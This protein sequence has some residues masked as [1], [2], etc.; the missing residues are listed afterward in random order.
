MGPP[1]II[2][3][4]WPQPSRTVHRSPG[5]A[6]SPQRQPQHDKTVRNGGYLL[7]RW[8]AWWLRCDDHGPSAALAPAGARRWT[9]TFPR[10]H[11]TRWCL[12]RFPGKAPFWRSRGSGAYVPFALR[13]VPPGV[14]VDTVPPG[15]PPREEQTGRDDPPPIPPVARHRPRRAPRRQWPA[16]QARQ[17]PM[18]ATGTPALGAGGPAPAQPGGWLEDRP[19]AHRAHPACGPSARTPGPFIEFLTGQ[20]ARLEMLTQRRY[21][22]ITVGIG[23]PHLREPVPV[24][25][26]VHRYLPVFCL[27]Q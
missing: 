24:L 3:T 15:Q 20:P 19:S 25:R 21:H 2:K 22:P 4:H 18:P 1:G 26:R 10:D 14:P 17:Q 12:A 7:V 23:G 5:Y 9:C 16:R 6:P 11:L 27:A 8:R 13:S